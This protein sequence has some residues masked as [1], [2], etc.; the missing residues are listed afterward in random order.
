M[1]LIRHGAR[2]LVLTTLVSSVWAQSPAGTPAATPSAVIPAQPATA[3]AEQPTAIAAIPGGA[4]DPAAKANPDGS[5][6][7]DKDL[8]KNLAPAATVNR[9]QPLQTTTTSMDQVADR[10]AVSEHQFLK[11]MQGYTPLVETYVQNMKSDPDVGQR[12]A[13][14]VYFLGK[15]EL[16][17]SGAADHSLLP[18]PGFFH[19]VL[20]KMT[21]FFDMKYLPL[22]FAQMITPDNRGIDRQ[23]YDFQ[24]VRREFLGEI[25]CLVIDI[26]PKKG[27]GSGRF[28]GR[29]WVEDQ[30][31]NIVRFNGVYTPTP[32]F[33]SYLHFDSWRLNM[34]P[35]VWLPAYIYSEE[36]DIQYRFG[37]KHL[38][39]KS[40]TRLWGY[41]QHIVTN[42]SEFTEMVVDSVKDES[43]GPGHS[44]TPVESERAW[45]RQ[46]EDNVLERLTRAGLLAQPGDV[47]KVLQTVVNNLLVTN[48]LDIQPEVRC[49]ILLTAPMESFIV[50]RTIVLSRGMIDVLPD[51]ATLAA[52]LAH[53]L[54]HIALGHHFDT[55]FA[56]VDRMMFSDE[57]TYRKLNFHQNSAEEAAADQKAI[58][59]LRS[60]PYNDKLASVGLFVRMLETRE[61]ELPNLVRA[62]LGNSIAPNHHVRME[63][64]A[65]GAPQ[66]EIRKLDQIRRCPWVDGSTSILTLIAWSW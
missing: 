50:G 22:G 42:K 31:Y 17:S 58:A 39:F 52:V 4:A 8:N 16:T 43:A 5:S 48:N 27:S 25:R 19:V 62:H 60:S 15:L 38:R 37:L 61:H 55:K 49:R 53:E 13:S 57:A 35:G 18:K 9:Q 51:E 1:S 23:T 7:A 36:S 30:D 29:I 26:R 10:I 66:L 2:V 11:N 59:M 41:D 45:E 54:A 6:D 56:F 44:L 21:M 24:F 63:E 65:A 47:E 28:L 34:K 3:D 32:R 46:A 64:L 14:D 20:D 12:P 33:S 40:Q